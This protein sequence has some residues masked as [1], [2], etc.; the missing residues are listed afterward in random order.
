MV[1]RLLIESNCSV[2]SYE[3]L[4]KRSEATF[5]TISWPLWCLLAEFA[6]RA[7]AKA[8]QGAGAV[9]PT[10][11]CVKVKPEFSA[12]TKS[13]WAKVSIDMDFILPKTLEKSQAISEGKDIKM[14][15]DVAL[16]ENYQTCAVHQSS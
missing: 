7:S 1:P 10:Y 13:L 14:C 9:M 11:L 6:W 3:L 12:Y 5:H 8:E 2:R 16:E 15:N 4:R